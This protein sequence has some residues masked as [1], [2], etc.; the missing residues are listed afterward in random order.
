M[1]QSFL[2]PPFFSSFSPHSLPPLNM[3]HSLLL[4]HLHFCAY[5]PISFCFFIHFYLLLALITWSLFLP[6]LL[7]P[8]V[9]SH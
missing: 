5:S 9:R 3:G 7:L 2:C 8:C 4:S 1:C 6:T